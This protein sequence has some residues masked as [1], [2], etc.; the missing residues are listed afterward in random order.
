MSK[1]DKSDNNKF[2]GDS[3]IDA[4]YEQ[5]LSDY[6][7]KNHSLDANPEKFPLEDPEDHGE[8]TTADEYNNLLVEEFNSI[9]EQIQK[10][11]LC[12]FNNGA[13]L[14]KKARNEMCQIVADN[15]KEFGGDTGIDA[16]YLYEH[17]QINEITNGDR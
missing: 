1:K 5:A 8:P 2:G 13:L 7:E 15:F 16:D 3:G 9:K 12:Y 6:A 10:D 11:L 17:N 4:D 14:T